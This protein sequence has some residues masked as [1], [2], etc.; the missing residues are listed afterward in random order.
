MI[1]HSGTAIKDDKLVT[2]GGRVLSVVAIKSDLGH[3]IR[4]AQLAAGMI[5]FNGCFYRKDIAYRAVLR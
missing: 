2:N 3:A 1:F 4:E 5:T